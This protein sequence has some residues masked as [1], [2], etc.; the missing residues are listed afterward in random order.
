[1]AQASSTDN[2]IIAFNDLR[3]ED[4]LINQEIY[5]NNFPKTFNG[6]VGIFGEVNFQPS[7]LSNRSDIYVPQ[8][9]ALHD[10]PL[11]KRMTAWVDLSIGGKWQKGAVEH[12]QYILERQVM[13]NLTLAY[14][15]L[16]SKSLK[17]IESFYFFMFH[18]R[19]NEYNELPAE[20]DFYKE[21]DQEY[22]SR[23][24]SGFERAIADSANIY[25]DEMLLNKLI[26][27][28]LGASLDSTIKKV[29][30]YYLTRKSTLSEE[31]PGYNAK[32]K[33]VDAHANSMS[34]VIRL[35]PLMGEEYLKPYRKILT[36]I[37]DF[38]SIHLV[39]GDSFTI[40]SKW[41]DEHVE[42]M[43]R[44]RTELCSY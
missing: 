35:T 22:Y 14:G 13:T 2:L 16:R 7:P 33:A 36:D 28:E 29:E 21:S 42:K 10:I 11:A 20:F 15:V 26:L 5:F 9:F 39:A 8:F 30:S 32:N 27:C 4:N 1:M 23:V 37:K 38:L 41:I 31:M 3:T 44:I 40:Y 19:H 25:K 12:F 18:N 43:Q 34:Y 24:K 17:E 6:F